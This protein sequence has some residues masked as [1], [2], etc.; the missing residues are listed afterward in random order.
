M[1][2]AG[3]MKGFLQEIL[4]GLSVDYADVRVEETE[5]SHVVYRGEDLDSIGRNFERGGCIRAFHRGNWAV[6]TF[7]VIDDGLRKL[8]EEAAEQV[9]SLPPQDAMVA[10]LGPHEEEVRIEPGLDVRDVSLAEKHGLIHHYN[11]ILTASPGIATTSAIY[12]DAH[13]YVVFYSTEDRYIDQEFSEC[14]FAVRAVAKDGTDIQEYA[15]SCGKPQ[16]VGQDALAGLRHKEVFVERVAKVAL[17]LLRAEPVRCGRY[18]VIVDPLLAGVFAHEA[19]G[20]L[21]E[22]DHIADN[23]RL[24]ELMNIGRRL[25]AENLSIIDDATM[26]GERGSFRYDDEGAASEPTELIRHGILV[27]HLHNR[28]TAHQLGEPPTGNGRAISY[29]FPPVVRMTNTYVEPRGSNL[30][31]MLDGMEQGLYVCGS[32]GGMTELES[33]TFSSQYAYLVE[34]G[35]KT[36]MVRDATL[37][38][39]VFETL[40]N[41]AAIGDDLTL[42]G[43]IG[44]CGKSGQSPLPVGLGAPHL[45]IKNVVIGGR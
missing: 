4:K 21:S 42:F 24:R 40:M 14:G 8:A 12:R 11:S 6:A 17:E 36:K 15:D 32:R 7:N 22:A 29:R 28:Q 34:H 35:R 31:D 27:S 13:R 43:G 1:A 45:K 20:H 23:E 2:E 19:F 9:E 16:V 41:I 37:S 38:G 44:G 30:D 18:T 39:N 33:F 25:G 26:P 3:S 10:T 5:R